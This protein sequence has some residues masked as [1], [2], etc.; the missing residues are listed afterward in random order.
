MAFVALVLSGMLMFIM[1]IMMAVKVK[2]TCMSL[3]SVFACLLRR[4]LG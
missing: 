4:R 2:V 3:H 1:I